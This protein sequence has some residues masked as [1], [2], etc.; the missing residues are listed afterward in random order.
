MVIVTALTIRIS[1]ISTSFEIHKSLS[2]PFCIEEIRIFGHTDD[3]TTFNCVLAY[4]HAGPAS[5]LPT[6]GKTRHSGTAAR[7][8]SGSVST[9]GRERRC[10]GVG[11]P[12][13]ICRA[14]GLDMPATYTRLSLA[15]TCCGREAALYATGGREGRGDRG[16]A[17][18]HGRGVR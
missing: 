6:S 9:S 14:C 15:L 16:W 5:G 7:R 11:I 12:P 18:G 2:S 4:A 1:T 13:S 17:A 10:G 3:E 8:G